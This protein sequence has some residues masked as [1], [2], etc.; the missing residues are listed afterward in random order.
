MTRE[1]SQEYRKILEAKQADAGRTLLKNRHKLAAGK[2][3]AVLEEI[4]CNAD[5]EL[6]VANFGRPSGL[7]CNI[8]PAL[9]RMEDEVFGFGP[10][11]GMKIDVI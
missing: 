2:S 7:L 11:G 1:Q 3:R 9:V 5:P 10:R 6:V 4:L 8:R